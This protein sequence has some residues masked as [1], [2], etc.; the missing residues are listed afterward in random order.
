MQRR[1]SD[2]V[3]GKPIPLSILFG[4]GPACL[5]LITRLW[6]H[7]GLLSDADIT[8]M[9]DTQKQTHTGQSAQNVHKDKK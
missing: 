7:C 6:L 1:A 3:G 5:F 4:F 9:F 8:N 2:I